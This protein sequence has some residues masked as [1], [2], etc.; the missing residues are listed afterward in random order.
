MCAHIVLVVSPPL[1]LV[2]NKMNTDKMLPRDCVVPKGAQLFR[3]CPIACLYTDAASQ[4]RLDGDTG[5]VGVYFGTY[6]AVS[7]AIALE[8]RSDRVQLAEFR[9]TRDLAVT[10]GKYSF[11]KINPSRYFT[12]TG[13]FIPKVVPLPS[14]NISHFDAEAWPLDENHEQLFPEHVSLAIQN[15]GGGELFLTEED[16]T[17]VELV[18]SFEVPSWRAVSRVLLETVPDKELVERIWTVEPYLK[19]G[20]I[21]EFTCLTGGGHR[22]RY[23]R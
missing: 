17:A 6:P 23:A 14:E 9:L 5:K 12:P 15:A 2:R 20:A 22:G 4:A 8:N 10:Y 7:L 21:L 1:S 18:R 13:K 3:L 19:E 16:L 11:R